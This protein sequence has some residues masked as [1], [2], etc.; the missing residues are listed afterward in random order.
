MV[1]KAM[2]LKP[3]RMSKSLVPIY[4]VS[5]DLVIDVCL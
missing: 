2:D 3:E 1:Y 4:M 5:C